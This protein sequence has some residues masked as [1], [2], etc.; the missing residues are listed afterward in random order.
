M[1]NKMPADRVIR[2]LSCLQPWGWI[3]LYLDKRVENRGRPVLGLDYRGDVLLHAS[4]S[5]GR[6]A[7]KKHWMGAHGFVAERFG[8]EAAAKIPP[9]GHL[10]MGGIVGRAT[11]TGI[12]RPVTGE[13]P[14][15]PDG[16]DPRWHMQERFGYLLSGARATPFV[17]WVGAQAAIVAPEA[18]LVSIDDAED[19]LS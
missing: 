2:V 16:V 14:K 4:K 3:V 12:V 9:V 8:A 7:D 15:Y 11:V 5:K 13:P 1:N 18:L 19:P 10:P 17:P 6:V